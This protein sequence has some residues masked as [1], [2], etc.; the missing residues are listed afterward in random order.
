MFSALKG[1]TDSEVM[2]YLAITFGL[3]QDVPGA[4]ARMAGSIEGLG[5]EQGVELPLRMTAAVSDGERLWAFR[6][7]SLRASRS[8]FCST[9]ADTVQALQPDLE[10]LSEASDGTRMVVSEPLGG[11]PGEWNEVPESSYGVIRPGVDAFLLFVPEP[12]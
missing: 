8:L 7:S 12:A 9:G 5:H 3:D 11:L 1:S 6:Y 2:F 4:V 10:V